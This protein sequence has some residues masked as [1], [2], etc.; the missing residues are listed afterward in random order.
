M[1]HII[2]RIL[3][4]VRN[5]ILLTIALVAVLLLWT[6][7]DLGARIAVNAASWQLMTCM[8]SGQTCDADEL[9]SVALNVWPTNN[10]LLRLQGISRWRQGD[11]AG[12]VAAL[13]KIESPDVNTRFFLAHALYDYGQQ[14]EAIRL[15]R[16]LG[17]SRYFVGS[18]PD[19]ALL[20]APFD[21]DLFYRLGELARERGKTPE[22]AG[23]F[24]QALSLEAA[25]SQR[26]L[27]AKAF[28]CEYEQRWA[29]AEQTYKKAIQLSPN[30]PRAYRYL[31]F[32]YQLKLGQGIPA[33]EWYDRAIA[34]P[35]SDY[36]SCLFAGGLLINTEPARALGYYLQSVRLVYPNP[37]GW[38]GVGLAEVAL[39]NNIA[40]IRSL[41]RANKE[42][43]GA[44]PPAI[45]YGLGKAHQQLGEWETAVDYLCRSLEEGNRATDVYLSLAKAY[46]MGG[47]YVEVAAT[48]RALL[49]IE[50]DNP[51]A[52]SGL[53]AAMNDSGCP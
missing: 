23:F 52:L 38:M 14:D 37:W 30:D 36:L 16:T 27:L 49:E 47:R 15:Y 41:Y 12:A 8:S 39:G 17:A 9:L 21:V 32:M 42:L 40:A 20:I 50:P 26:S 28:L 48:Y 10:A 1:I 35:Q 25:E 34:L 3:D 5:R 22:A 4:I 24:R 2:L 46:R 29:D 31:G 11:Q 13:S 51:R 45:S 44:L 53:R 19:I 7:P 43:N 6:I 33:L 18:N